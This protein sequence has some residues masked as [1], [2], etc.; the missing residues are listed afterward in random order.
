M[1]KMMSKVL[2]ASMA[3]NR[4][5]TTSAGRSSGS[6]MCQNACTRGGPVEVRRLV[7]LARQA[8][9]P[10]QRDQHD[11]RRPLP[12]VHQGQRVQR[13]LTRVRP[14]ERRETDARDSEVVRHAERGVIHHHEHERDRRRRRHHGQDGQRAQQAAPPEL[15]IEEQRHR[16]A[17]HR[18]RRHRHDREVDGPHHRFPESRVAE[19]N[20]AVVRHPDEPRRASGSTRTTPGGSSTPCRRSD[21]R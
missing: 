11:Q 21:T 6:V 8:G 19:E 16:H 15:P 14:A 1:T 4:I 2:S 20:L 10:G 18:L 12:H 5:A 13:R 3:R 7:G 9:E 17:E